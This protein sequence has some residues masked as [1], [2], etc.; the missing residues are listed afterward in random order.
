MLKEDIAA[1]ELNIGQIYSEAQIYKF[2]L[3]NKVYVICAETAQYSISGDGRYKV[4]QI[5]KGYVHRGRT[6]WTYHL[7]DKSATV[8]VVGKVLEIQ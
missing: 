5:L 3:E 4:E 2:I 7:P 1:T 8:Y 6:R